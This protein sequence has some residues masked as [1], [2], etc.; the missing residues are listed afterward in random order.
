MLLEPAEGL[1][2][3]AGVCSELSEKGVQLVREEEGQHPTEPMLIWASV[4]GHPVL[5]SLFLA[6]VECQETL[7]PALRRLRSDMEHGPEG[8]GPSILLS[9]RL[10]E[11]QRDLRLRGCGWVGGECESVPGLGGPREFANQLAGPL[12]GGHAVVLGIE[13]KLGQ[14]GLGCAMSLARVCFDPVGASP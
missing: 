5:A 7:M 10:A 6:L 4:A 8:P 9:K 14:E 12:V 2:G 13:V 3:A 1:L 11:T